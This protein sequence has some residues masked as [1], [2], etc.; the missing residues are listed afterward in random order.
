MTVTPTELPEVLVIEPRVFADERG[1]FFESWN[2][3]AF[4][5]ATGLSVG[6][7]QDNQSFSKSGVLRGIHY[8]VVK[9]QGKLVF[10]AS[11]SV[12]D[13]AVDLRKSS[14]RFGRWVAVELNDTNRR[15]MWIPPGFGHGFLVKSDS[16]LFLYK[17]TEYWYSEH[18]R[19]VRW[20]DPQLGVDWG[21]SHAPI[22]ATKDSVAPLLAN[23]EVYA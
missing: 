19:S 2:A 13:V 5:Q 3:S 16:A 23:A 4:A 22:L 15:Q 6:F 18:D 1:Y 7:V 20:N 21:L 17:T 9:P 8:Q 14:P 11:G 10:V 12:L